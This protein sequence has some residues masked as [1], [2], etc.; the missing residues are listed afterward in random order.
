MTAHP[1]AATLPIPAVVLEIDVQT[2][3]AMSRATTRA[4]TAISPKAHRA[5]MDALGIEAATQEAQG[6]PM[7]ELVAALIKGHLDQLK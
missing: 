2:A 7:A 6:G 1:A 4:V 5:M 3:L